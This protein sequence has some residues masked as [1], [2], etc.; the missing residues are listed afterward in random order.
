MP[1]PTEKRNASR[2][3]TRARRASQDLR[4]RELKLV[5]SSLL[6]TQEETLQRFFLEAKWLRNSIVARGVF[7]WKPVDGVHV[8]LPG[9]QL[10]PRSISTLPAHAKQT[11]LTGLQANVK[12]LAAL[13]RQGKK[14]GKIRFACRVNSIEFPTG[15]VKITGN[16]AAVPKLGTVRVRGGGQLGAEIAN[17]RLVR[18]AS[19]YYLLVSSLT[20]KSDEAQA[21]KLEPVGLD[22][23]IKTHITL[24]D[25]RTWNLSVEEPER[26]RRLQRKLQRQV[27]GSNNREATLVQLKRSYERLNHRKNEAANQLVA[28]LKRHSVV[29]YQDENLRGWKTRKG[30]GRVVHHS[31]MGRV[32]AKL[33]RLPQAVMVE[34]FAPT[35]QLCPK[36]GSLNKLALGERTYSCDCGYAAQRDVHAANNMLLFAKLSPPERR[37]A[38]VEVGA[39]AKL[40]TK[41]AGEVSTPE[42]AGNGEIFSFARS[43]YC[44]NQPQGESPWTL[45]P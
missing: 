44:L 36:C 38:P 1:T 12:T 5:E 26:L 3:V 29:A 24:S 33:S 14:V 45:L 23:G 11:V 17:V 27:K 4:V 28:E 37:G 40:A 30:Y 32:K 9:G 10:E 22:F 13:A 6:K 20:A 18:R 7:E 39:S 25:G 2:A 42:E 19:G 35:T 8:R 34:R 41:V 16:K 43:S 31:A 15:D 21:P